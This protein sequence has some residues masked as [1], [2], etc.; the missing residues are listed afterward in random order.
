ISKLATLIS[1]VP[2]IF[3]CKREGKKQAVDRPEEVEPQEKV[4]LTK[5]VLINPVYPEQL[6]AIGKSLSSEG[7]MQLKNLLKKNK[8]IF[9][10]EPADMTEKSTAR[11]SQSWG[12]HS[13]AFSMHT[14]A[15][16][17]YRWRRKTGRNPP[18]TQ[19]KSHI[20]QN[21]EVYI[22]DMVVKRKSK[23]ETL[24]DIA[25]TFNNLK[26]INMKLN[27]KKCSFWV[28]EGKFLGY[29]VT[30]E[31][32]RANPAKT[33][34]VAEMQSPRTW[35]EIKRFPRAQED[36]PRPTG[37]NNS[38][39]KRN[40]VRIPSGIKRSKRNY[41]PLEKMALALR[42]VSRRLRRNIRRTINGYGGDKCSSR[43]RGETWMTPIIN[44][45][46]KEVYQE[47][48]N[49]ARA[50]RM[51]IGEKIM[52]DGVL[53]KRS[54]LI[55]MLWCVGPLQANYVIQE[56]HLRACSMH[57]KARSVVEKAIRQGYYCP[58]MHRDARE[59]RR[60]S[61]FS[62]G[63]GCAKTTVR[64]LGESKVCNCS[65]GLF[66]KVDG[67]QIA[68][69]NNRKSETNMPTHRTMMI[70]E[71]DGND[72][73]MR[74]NL[75]LLT[76][77]RE[78]S[79]IREARYIM[80]IERY[81]NKRVRTMSFKMGEYVYRKNKASRMENLGKLGPNG[82]DHTWRWKH[83]RMA[84]TSCA[85]WTTGKYSASGVRST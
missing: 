61:I 77:I 74:L 16:T 85:Q 10:W 31:G 75:D 43:R 23:R 63:N 64:S 33:K 81:Y 7:S 14:R 45:L 21:L 32:I 2:I 29:M 57:L 48:Q 6:V 17:K 34:D 1:Q 22:D 55:P 13:N 58:M 56:I 12:F 42:H 54:Y 25:E 67:G 82:K 50:L 39:A 53:F 28:V 73:E 26:R 4:S 11:S 36:G 40:P 80:K 30:L 66:Y 72:E 65:R 69:Q 27:P 76:E 9:A 19:I 59:E 60:K 83:I 47:D 3:E 37:P 78:A 41:A 51:K 70:K 24:A 44:C 46:E 62:M 5:H 49:E 18:S 71:G 38:L 52:E 68:S 84:H 20:G 15:T 8:D 35:G 79:A